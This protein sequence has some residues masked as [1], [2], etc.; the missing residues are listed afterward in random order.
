[1]DERQ[2]AAEHF[3]DEH[4]TSLHPNY[5][6]VWWW[7]LG[8]TVLELI[9]GTTQTGPAYPQLAKITMTSTSKAQR[10]RPCGIRPQRR[11]RCRTSLAELTEPAKFRLATDTRNYRAREG[12]QGSLVTETKLVHRDP[13]RGIKCGPGAVEVRMKCPRR[14]IVEALENLHPVG[15]A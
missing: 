7:L 6:G 10:V 4:V 15:Q 11:I 3:E 1:M 14:G 9:A 12:G 5:I 2:R 8:L 13:Q